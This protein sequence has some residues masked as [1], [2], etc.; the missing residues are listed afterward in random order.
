MPHCCEDN[1]VRLA[2]SYV[3]PFVATAWFRV[4]ATLTIRILFVD[5]FG[6]WFQ[7]TVVLV[8]PAKL[9][10][11]ELSSVITVLEAGAAVW[12]IKSPDP[13]APV[14]FEAANVRFEPCKLAPEAAPP[15][16]VIALG[17]PSLPNTIAVLVVSTV[18]R[19]LPLVFC[20]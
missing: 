14:P 12:K 8:E 17:V 5:V 11:W 9:G 13:P 1:L 18:N 3:T 15:R 20:T 6:V 7:L 19:L 4:V 2:P 16:M 10:L